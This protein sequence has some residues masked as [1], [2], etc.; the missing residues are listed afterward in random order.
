MQAL[1]VLIMLAGAGGVV[2]GFQMAGSQGMIDMVLAPLTALV[3]V[4]VFGVGAIC[5]NVGT[6]NDRLQSRAPGH[7]ISD[8]PVE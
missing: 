8:E 3:A 7:Q 1:G 5:F 4:G 6:I 2:F